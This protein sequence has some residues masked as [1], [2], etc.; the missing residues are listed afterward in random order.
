MKKS[1]VKALVITGFGLNC[2]K[3]T[4]AACQLAG[5]T[6]EQIHLNELIAGR[7]IG[8]ALKGGVG[9]LVGYVTTLAMKLVA[10]AYFAIIFIR[11]AFG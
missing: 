5:A 11:A 3:E 9:A 4:A 8:H 7:R 1:D 2:E 6:P 10:V